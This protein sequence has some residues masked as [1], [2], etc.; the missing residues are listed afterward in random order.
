MNDI[1]DLSESADSM[2]SMR[3]GDVDLPRDLVSAHAD[4]RLVLFVGAGASVPAPSSLPM[5]QDLARRIADDSQC[6]YSE[7][8]L[9]KPDELLGRIDSGEVDVHLRVRDLIAREDS[10]PNELHRAI[11]DLASTSSALRIVTTNHDRHMSGFLFTGVDEFEAPAL[12]LGNDFRGLVYLHG[13][14]RQDPD[15]LVVTKS[16]FGKAYMANGWATRFLET[17]LGDLAVLFIGYSLNDTLMQYLAEALSADAEMYALTRKPEDPRWRDH[18]VV[19]VRYRGHEQLPDLIRQWADRAGMGMLDHDRRIAAIVSGAPPLLPEDESYLGAAVAHPEQVGLFT[20][21]ARSGEWL[22]WISSR[23]QFKALFDPSASFGRIEHSLKAWFT[24]HY[25]VNEDLAGDALALVPSNGGLVNRELWF[26]LVQRLSNNRSEATDRWIPVLIHTMPTGCNEWLGMLLRGYEAR[27]HNDLAVMLLDKI[28]E[29]RLVASRLDPRRMS[30]VA[31]SEENWLHEVGSDLLN[32]D[33][34]DLAWDL[35]P[36]LDRH[37]RQYFA[38]SRAVGSSEEQL[39]SESTHRASIESDGEDWRYSEVDHLIDI[40]RDVLEALVADDP[41]VAYGYLRVWSGHEWAL[42]RRLAVH[43]WTLRQ[44]VSADE[45]LLWLGESD[46]LMDGLLR[47]EVMRLLKATLPESRPGTIETLANGICG[48]RQN[49]ERYAYCLLAWIVQHAPEAAVAS[50]ALAALQQGHPDWKP[51]EEADFPSWSQPLPAEDLMDPVEL[52]GLHDRIDADAEAAVAG[53]I[54]EKEARA[55]RGVDWTDALNAL[56]STVVE[57]PGDGV[58]VLKVLVRE[59]TGAPELE[60]DLG[61]AVLNSWGHAGDTESLTDAQCIRVSGLLPDVWRLGVER[62][63]DGCTVFSNSGWLISAEHHW[64]GMTARLWKEAVL[65]ERRS[66]VDGWSGL[67]DAARAGLEEILGGD[68]KASHFAQV[69][70]TTH[71]HLFFQ[72]DERWCLDNLLPMLDPSIDDHRAIRCWE[73]Y[74]ARGRASEELL[75]AGLLDH[76]VA[77]TSQMDGLAN[78]YPKA[79]T[80]Y[81]RLAASICIDTC[82]D[83]LEAGWLPRLV[84]SA[85]IETRVAWVHEIALRLSGLAADAADSHWSKWMRRYWED[86]LASTPVAMTPDEASAMAEWPVLLGGRYPEAAELVTKS[87]AG[88]SFG[89]R[90]LYRLSGLDRPAR[91]EPRPDHSIEHPELTARLL[92]HLLHNTEVPVTGSRLRHLPEVVARLDKPL[93]DLRMEP[94][95]SELLRHG[96]GEFVEWLQSQGQTANDST[97]AASLS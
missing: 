64:A 84:A 85:D 92:A 93:H 74:L 77:M 16:D 18:G 2:R 89:S 71:L 28:L 35:A 8:E 9:G 23:P 81:A 86:R 73:G 12:P 40:A 65:A 20:R 11:V 25:A 88:L 26:S 58:A 14:V 52:E 32:A 42:L 97:P 70:L 63:G 95:V 22:R 50:S 62:W 75:Q 39:R 78:R 3:F 68:S 1:E 51:L 4:G 13:S 48:A 66:A 17:L 80:S 94:I 96:F 46:L 27:Q 6:C 47:P 83:P 7:E 60:R 37:L 87:P 19:P 90:L 57:H 45:K 67:P 61:E 15:R 49:D 29:P 91:E 36:V 38:L 31:G 69:V 5:F 10:Q 82:I 54:N 30:V 44:D 21:H 41:E 59:P 53:L 79:R 76:L 33:R 56:F 43:G 55:R 24:D 34:R 72:L